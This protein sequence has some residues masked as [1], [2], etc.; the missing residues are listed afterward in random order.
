MRRLDRHALLTLWT[1]VALMTTACGGG[2]DSPAPQPPPPAPAPTP[3]SPPAP[4]PPAS[5]SGTVTVLDISMVD[6]DTNDP[7]QEQRA[8]NGTMSTAQPSNNPALVV[9]YVNE[10]GTGPDGPNKTAGDGCCLATR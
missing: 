9:G 6:S 1:S 3:P 5:I 7:L 10:P 8:P 2:G 4:V